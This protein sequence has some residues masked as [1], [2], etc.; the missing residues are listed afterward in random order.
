[1]VPEL[2]NLSEKTHR[3]LCAIRV[4]KGFKTLSEA[5]DWAL[6]KYEENFIK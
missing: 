1:M 5:L 2:V 6:G 4:Q 3:L